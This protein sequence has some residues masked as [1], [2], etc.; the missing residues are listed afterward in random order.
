M[1]ILGKNVVIVISNAIKRNAS[2]YIPVAK[3]ES[4]IAHKIDYI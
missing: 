4:I 2:H 1:K 3:M